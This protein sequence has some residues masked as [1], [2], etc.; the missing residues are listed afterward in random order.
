MVQAGLTSDQIC[1]SAGDF[2]DSDKSV[3]EPNRKRVTY[4]GKQPVDVRFRL[5]VV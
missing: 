3:T 4:K 1:V 5:C 2:T